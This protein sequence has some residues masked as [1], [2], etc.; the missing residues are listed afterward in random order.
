[1]FEFESENSEK[2]DEYD[3]RKE[4]IVNLGFNLGERFGS[5]EELDTK[6]KKACRDNYVYFHI[7]KCLPFESVK[8][9]LKHNCKP[10]LKYY[11]LKYACIFCNGKLKETGGKTVGGKS[12]K[13][14][15]GVCPAS[16]TI[17]ITEDGK[18]L[19]VFNV[20]N[21]HNHSVT[22]QEYEQFVPKPDTDVSNLIITEISKEDKFAMAF[23]KAN[24]IAK[25]VS[26]RVPHKVPEIIQNL[27]DFSFYLEYTGTK[28]TDDDYEEEMETDENN[29]T[30][31]ETKN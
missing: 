26:V 14:H 4:A 5:F 8:R 29:E 31:I 9:T 23:A 30:V 12:K 27:E 21:Y 10:E 19:E 25:L 2:P 18:F 7:T 15:V 20:E 11:N 22:K 17:K 6:F 24:L 16:I 28:L 13:S 1:M 3:R